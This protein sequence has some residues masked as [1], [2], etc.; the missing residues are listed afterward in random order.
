[1]ALHD[2]LTGLPNRVLFE[3]HLTEAMNASTAGNGVAVAFLDLDRFKEINDAFGH[4]FGDLVLCGISQRLRSAVR[5]SDI[6]ARLSG[7]E[8][9]IVL[10]NIRGDAD[11]GAIAGV[12]LGSCGAPLEIEGREVATSCSIGVAIHPQHGATQEELIRAADTA[13]YHAKESRNSW[14][15]YRPEMREWRSGTPGLGAL[16][17][18]LEQGD[19]TVHYQPIVAVDSGKTHA[20]EALVRWPHAS[21]F[22]PAADIVTLAETSGLIGPLTEFVLRASLRQMHKWDAHPDSAGLRLAV[23]ISALQVNAGLVGMIDRLLAELSF[24]ASRLDLE[25]TERAAMRTSPESLATLGALRDRGITL[26]LD[27]FGTGYSALSRLEG[28][29]IDAMKI[30]KSFLESVEVNGNGVIARA[31][32]AMA[33]ALGVTIVGEGVETPGQLAFLKRERCNFAQGY[34]LA[35]PATADALDFSIH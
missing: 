12:L 10:P 20:V 14:Q 18:A 8:F 22:V 15:T 1:M 24:D 28:L 2:M 25:L 9:A 19:L 3:R 27:D 32:I 7:D 31:I 6:V 5:K 34:Y 17:H 30:D 29:P 26:T 16:R 11:A 4:R 13:Q 35:R 21:G 33:H 23:N